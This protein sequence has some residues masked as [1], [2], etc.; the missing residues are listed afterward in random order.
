[1]RQPHPLPIT[2]DHR[3]GDAF[4]T[5]WTAMFAAVLAATCGV[6]TAGPAEATLPHLKEPG[7]AAFRQFATAEPHRAFAIAPG[8]AW[9]W[10]SGAPTRELAEQSVLEACRAKTQQTCV[11]Y[12][13]DEETVFDAAAWPTLWGPYKSRAEALR[14]AVGTRRGERFPDLAL[15]AE[16]G[17]T[18]ALSAWRGR[19][20]VL[21]F[22]GSWCGPCRQ[23]MPELQALRDSLKDRTD[24]AFVPVQVRESADTARRWLKQQ[25]LRLPLFD[26]GATGEA[27]AALRLADGTRL[28]DREVSA[29]FPTTYVLDRHGLVLFSHVGAVPRWQEYAAF[30]RDAAAKSGR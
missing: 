12:A 1:M 6:A 14:A 2:P 8:G 4:R 3:A 22:W 18:L 15:R 16:A 27:D 25:S 24:V 19:L 9:S 21:H 23:E 5:P 20:V 17:G 29:Q 7:Q 13:V 26:S 11:L 10:A 30:I 28:R